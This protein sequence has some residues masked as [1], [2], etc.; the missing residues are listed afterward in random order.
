LGQAARLYNLK[1]DPHEKKELAAT[2]Q[3][4]VE[5]LQKKIET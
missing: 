3:E 2:H 1:D 4:I 5:K